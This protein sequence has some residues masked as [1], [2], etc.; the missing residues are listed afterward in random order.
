MLRL[1]TLLM[2]AAL[3]AVPGRAPQEAASAED[4]RRLYYVD[5]DGGRDTASGT[6]PETPWKTLA[7]LEAVEWRPGD[8]VR[9]RAGRT[10][11]ETLTVSAS[12]APD[13]P[14]TFEPY[15]DGPAP[16]LSGADPVG[17]WRPRRVSVWAAQGRSSARFEVTAYCADVP[18][19]PNQVFVDGQRLVAAVDAS[20]LTPGRFAHDPRAGV[21]CLRLGAGADPTAHRVEASARDHVIDIRNRQHLSFAG[22]AVVHANR[23]AF[24]IE[25]G[26]TDLVLTRMTLSGNY[27][28]GFDSWSTGPENSRITIQD[29]EV[30]DNGANG[31]HFSDRSAG[32]R[33]L[34]NR[35]HHNA[36]LESSDPLHLYTAGIK[37]NASSSHDVLVEGNVVYGNGAAATHGDRGAGIWLDTVGA[38]CVVRGNRSFENRFHGIFIEV[39]SGALV[40][41]NASYDNGGHE[42]W[43]IGL[44]VSGRRAPEQADG[45]RVFHNVVWNSTRRPRVSGLAVYGDGSPNAITD[46]I[47]RNNIVGGFPVNLRAFN[48][49]ENDGLMGSG[50]V[51]TH[52]AFGPERAGFIEWGHG[53]HLSRYADWQMA[54]GAPTH[55]VTGDPLLIDPARGLFALHSASPARAAALPLRPLTT[56]TDIGLATLPPPASRELR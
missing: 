48:G 17:G 26:V 37:G 32:W 4:P 23:D 25:D 10:W 8:G 14:L 27:F 1:L 54:Y 24:W 55:S 33:I 11:R 12:G 49:G 22:L 44:A 35:V 56:S 3:I 36:L 28:H 41:D 47:V 40:Y 29:S 34:R 39:T 9:L 38:G 5:A 51:Y 42:V 16:V 46:T 30:A 7:R 43:S 31:I 2:G 52:N 53:R 20:G 13:R 6:T 21:L 45:N 19:A 15:G 18:D 50:N